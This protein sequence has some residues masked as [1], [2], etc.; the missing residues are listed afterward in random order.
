MNASS[1]VDGNERNGKQ[2]QIDRGYF[3][4][5]AGFE[6]SLIHQQYSGDHSAAKN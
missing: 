2:L 6:D 4:V 1:R 3:P 5:P